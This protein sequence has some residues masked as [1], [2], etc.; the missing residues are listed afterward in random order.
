MDPI[1]FRKRDWVPYSGW[2]FQKEHLDPFYARAHPYVELGPYEYEVAHYEAQDPPRKRLPF[3]EEKVWTKM[4]QFSPPTRFG[5]RYR[6]AIVDAD[7][8]HLYTYANVTEV[9]AN[10]SVRAVAGLRAQTIDGKRHRVRARYYVLACGSIQNARI[11]LASNRQALAGLGNDHDLVG[12]FFMEHIEMGGA[13]LILE[14]PD[15]MAMYALRFGGQRLPTGELA[16]TEQ[17]QQHHRILNGTASLRPG[18]FPEEMRGFFQNFSERALRQSMRDDGEEGERPQRPPNRP[19]ASAEGRR[20]YRLQSRA[21]QMPNPASRVVLSTENDALGMPYADLHW[22][23]SALDKQSMRTFFDI[24]AHEFGRTGVGRLQILDWLLEDDTSWPSFL[25]G[26]FH[27]MGTTRM[28]DDPKQGVLDANAKVHSVENLYVA[29]ASAFPTSGAPNPTLT[30]IALT[31]RL[32]DH[33]K[34]KIA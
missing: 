28:H 6:D 2:P 15:P 1:D 16:L 9:E 30:L 29:G 27:H 34:Q 3:D 4:W 8:I 7:N 12:R 13:Q 17:V 21:E 10:E 14:N 20:D 25:S 18:T 5:T 24:V 31:L 33:L 19:A 11:L 32:S 22:K 23:L 26:G